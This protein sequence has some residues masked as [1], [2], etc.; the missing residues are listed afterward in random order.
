M[1]VQV[2]LTQCHSNASL[3][4]GSYGNS[5]RRGARSRCP[6]EFVAIFVVSCLRV[7]F[8]FSLFRG[9][10]GGRARDFPGNSRSFRLLNFFDV[11]FSW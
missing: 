9:G 1:T 7:R 6:T 11:H 3:L 10:R 4:D 5:K 8:D 2:V